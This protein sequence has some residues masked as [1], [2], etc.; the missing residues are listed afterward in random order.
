MLI[1]AEVTALTT[2]TVPETV[3]NMPTRHQNPPHPKQHASIHLALWPLAPC[4]C[5][6]SAWPGMHWWHRDVYMKIESCPRKPP[7]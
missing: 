2:D 5:M 4:L 7:S 6:H 1:Q 3:A